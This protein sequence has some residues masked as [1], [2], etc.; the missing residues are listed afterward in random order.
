MSTTP[1]G[2][3]NVALSRIGQRQYI[4]AFDEP[5][6]EAE[7][8]N[9]LFEHCRDVV[10]ARMAWPFATA[11]ATLAESTEERDN[12]DFVYGLP[13]NFVAARYLVPLGVQ[14]ARPDQLYPYAIELNDANDARLLLTDLEDA[15]LVY[16]R[17]ITSVALFPPLFQ[18]ALAWKLAAEL[19][20]VLPV[21]PGVAQAME[22]RYEQVLL[23]AG[24]ADFRQ[25][26]GGT[27]PDGSY[28]RSRG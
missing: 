20:L 5:T 16:T 13:A 6:T 9:N 17:A 18:D 15:V 14:Y 4:S 24:A 12:W 23:Q 22:A 11:R 1:V 2:L 28:I 8:C 10:L 3:S 26:K 7:A 27:E 19:A 25:A 21:K